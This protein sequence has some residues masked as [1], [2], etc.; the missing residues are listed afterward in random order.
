MIKVVGRTGFEHSI[1]EPVTV[2]ALLKDLGLKEQSYVC[3]RNDAPVTRFDTISPE[4]DVVFME[5]FSGG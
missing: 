2:E 4:D 3:I 1:S 5:I